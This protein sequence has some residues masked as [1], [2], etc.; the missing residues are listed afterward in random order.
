MIEYNKPAGVGNLKIVT[1][2]ITAGEFP[3]LFSNPKVILPAPPIGITYVPVSF[4][5]FMRWLVDGLPTYFMLG[6]YNA[7]TS[8]LPQPHGAYCSIKNLFNGTS[9]TKLFTLGVMAEDK[10]EENY[11]YQEPII[12]MTEQNDVTGS[13]YDCPY[14]FAYYEATIS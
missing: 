1:G 13:Y 3:T 2:S 10:S 8:A 5:I 14:S 11:K 12:F 4:T 6:N 7:I 9:F